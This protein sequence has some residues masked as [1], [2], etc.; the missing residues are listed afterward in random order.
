MMMW[1]QGMGTAQ[2]R[3]PHIGFLFQGFGWL[4]L[5]PSVST[6]CQHLQ[7]EVFSGNVSSCLL[8]VCLLDLRQKRPLAKQLI[9]DKAIVASI[10]VNP[11]L[12]DMKSVCTDTCTKLLENFPGIKTNSAETGSFHSWRRWELVHPSYASSWD[13]WHT[14]YWLDRCLNTERWRCFRSWF[15]EWVLLQIPP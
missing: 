13:S 8:L 11:P 2:F 6:A 1:F 15:V 4:S 7:H 14:P 5:F 9:S 3:S 10:H 12:M